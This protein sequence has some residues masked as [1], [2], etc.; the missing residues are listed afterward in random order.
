MAAYTAETTLPYSAEQLFDVA[1]DVERYPEFLPGW[2]A[3]RVRKRSGDSYC[4]DQ[5]I[6]FGVLRERFSTRTVLHRPDRIDV[7]SRERPFR[8]FELTWEFA[9]MPDGRCRV[10]LT[11]RIDF[12]AR[13][14]EGLFGHALA[15]LAEDIVAAFARRAHRLYAAGDSQGAARSAR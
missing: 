5:I 12:R 13:I 6:S 15:R 8:D 1:A 9:A 3:A 11:T 14:V 2:V 10:T 7:T 4:T